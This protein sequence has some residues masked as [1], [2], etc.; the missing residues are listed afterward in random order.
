[1]LRLI[2]KYQNITAI[3]FLLIFFLLIVTYGIGKNF[4]PG[5]NHDAAWNGLYAIRILKG[6]PLTVYTPEAFGQETLFHYVMSIFFYF[7]G[8][9]KETIELASTFF[10]LISVPLIYYLIF[11]FVKDKLYSFLLSLIFIK[12]RSIISLL[13]FRILFFRIK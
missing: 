13:I 2:K 10:G 5:L 4:P 9:S 1:M 3:S 7:L 12:I 11:H 8:S 6:E